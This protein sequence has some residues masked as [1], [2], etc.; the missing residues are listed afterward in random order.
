LKR[1]NGRAAKVTQSL[2]EDL[3]SYEA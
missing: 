3:Q 1:H 2:I